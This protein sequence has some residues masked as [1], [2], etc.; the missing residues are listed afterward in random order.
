MNA[1][2]KGLLKVSG[3]LL[4]IIGAIYTLLGVLALGGSFSQAVVEQTMALTGATATVIRIG[5]IIMLAM[6]LFELIVGI[7]G[8]KN[9]DKPEKAQTCFV[10]G[11]MLVLL[12]LVNAIMAVMKGSFVWY[13]TVIDLL[14]PILYLVGALKNKEASRTGAPEISG[15]VVEE[16]KEEAKEEV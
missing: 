13:F 15:N 7:L 10:A 5:A 9:C 2:G 11:I 16:A 6:G 4:I 14:F 3:I 8:V 1:P 12:V